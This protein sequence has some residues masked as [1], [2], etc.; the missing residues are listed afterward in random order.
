MYNLAW[1]ERVELLVFRAR[2]CNNH[3]Q[4]LSGAEGNH[5]TFRVA[6]RAPERP[7][8]VGEDLAGRP[9]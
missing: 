9:N 1:V 2:K 6:G 4:T 5:C 8:V 7:V 3:H